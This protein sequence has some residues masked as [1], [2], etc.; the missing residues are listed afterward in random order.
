MPYYYLLFADAVLI[1]L[2]ILL[3][4][5]TTPWH[6]FPVDFLFVPAAMLV[7]E[8][9]RNLIP[10]ALF[11]AVMWLGCLSVSFSGKNVKATLTVLVLAVSGVVTLV[12]SEMDKYSRPGTLF[13]NSAA[14]N[15]LRD[16]SWTFYLIVLFIAM[17]L[18]MSGTAFMDAVGVLLCAALSVIL[19]LRQ[20]TGRCFYVRPK[21]EKYIVSMSDS[22][23]KQPVIKENCNLD[24][25]M[26]ALYV[27]AV[28]YMEQ[29]APYL[30][31]DFCLDSFARDLLTNRVYLSRTIN[32][33]SGQNFR[34]FVNYY[35]VRYSIGLMKK[36]KHMM[37]DELAAL[38]GF[39][40]SVSYNTAFRLFMHESPKEWMHNHHMELENGTYSFPA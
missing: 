18:I 12:W 38:S 33:Y 39:H 22:I 11:V 7:M 21:T 24:L 35:R 32:I 9:K 34:Q 16:S 31:E 29:K 36:D 5:G 20:R 10:P 1:A 26:N 19:Y 17:L 14:L 8:R 27:K 2:D 30:R 23:L 25:K 13:K 3:A 37:V 6:C 40:S 4:H 28:D 15:S